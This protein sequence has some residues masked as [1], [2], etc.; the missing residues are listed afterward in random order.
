MWPW[1]VL[2]EDPGMQRNFFDLANQLKTQQAQ[3]WA[4][5]PRASGKTKGAHL[6]S[7]TVPGP[8]V[9]PKRLAQLGNRGFGTSRH[10][11]GV[12]R[13]IRTMNHHN[14]DNLTAAPSRCKLVLSSL[15]ARRG[16]VEPVAK[17]SDPKA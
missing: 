2:I 14:V 5:V 16:R 11:V 7:F 13:F 17:A 15:T 4:F 3:C 8:L 6:S 9:G 1:H 12:L 10:E